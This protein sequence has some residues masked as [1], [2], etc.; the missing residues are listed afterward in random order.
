MTVSPLNDREKLVLEDSQIGFIRFVAM[1]L[2]QRVRD[3]MQGKYVYY[4]HKE[5]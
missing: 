4:H 3:V 5:K 1:G 2:F